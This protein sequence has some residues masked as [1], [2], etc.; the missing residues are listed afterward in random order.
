MR[1]FV[2]V[3]KGSCCCYGN[4]KTNVVPENLEPFPWRGTT[5]GSFGRATSR[6]NGCTEERVMSEITFG[7]VR[8]S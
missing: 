1:L 2:D 5:W 4:R 8:T 7:S 6:I 3:G